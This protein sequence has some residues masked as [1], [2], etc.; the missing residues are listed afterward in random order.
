M[1]R[2]LFMGLLNECD[3]YGSFEW[4]PLKLKMR[5]LPADNADA[6][7]LLA[8]LISAGSIMRYEIGA[9]AYG[10][11]RNFCQYQR[12][13]KPTSSY[14]QTDEVRAWVNTQARSTRDGSEEVPHESGT[15][16]EKARQMKDGG[17]KKSSEANA[18]AGK[19]ADPIKD[20]YDLGVA[21][22]TESGITEE[23]ARSLL[24][25]WRK[26]GEAAVFQ[27]LLE[28]RSK[29]ISNPVE[30][31]T[32]RLQVPKWVSKNGYEYRGTAEQVLKEAE[33]RNDMDTYWK[34]KSSMK[35]A[36]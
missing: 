28:C 17:G 24:G 7:E 20:V 11:V 3:D 4:A 14:P 33:R 13:K 21:V 19:P 36:A 1:A 26:A 8:E 2:L 31:L 22:L 16:G 23:R 29:S 34:V 9:K 12:P 15:S 10:A 18:S 35:Q 5:L 27:A 32:K 25:K 6:A 30:W